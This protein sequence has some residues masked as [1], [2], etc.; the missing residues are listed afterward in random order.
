MSTVQLLQ[1]LSQDLAEAGLRGS[2]V[3]RNLD[4]GEEL[5]LEPDVEYA[6]ASLVKV[7]IALATLERCRRG[8]LDA[9]MRLMVQP[10]RLTLRGPTGLSK[11]RHPV[12]IALD[13]LLYLSTSLSDSTAA[14]ALFR[15]TPPALV[16]STLLAYGVSGIAIRHLAGVLAETPAA[17]FAPED[18]RFAHTLAITAR[19]DGRGHQ[20]EQLDVARASSASA[21]AFVD[22]L[23]ALWSPSTIDPDVAASVRGLMADA[24][25]RHRLAPDF[26]SD[27]AQWSS[28]TATLL[29]LRHEIGVVEHA[30][31]ERYGIAALTE[32]SVAAAV[33]PQAEATMARVA[34]ALRDE[35]RGR[36]P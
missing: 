15:L 2:F 1:R 19:T 27:A 6:T 11:F 5:S 3:V 32:S 34:R 12:E 13:D 9:S 24:V 21:R 31:G 7:P 16:T 29:N 26:S 36:R 8:E 20:V 35:L 23:Q 28:K 17:R 10:G 33:Q 18:A 25:F 4:T 22:L 14:D 30:D